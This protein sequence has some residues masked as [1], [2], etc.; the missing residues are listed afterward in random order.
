MPE[1]ELPASGANWVKIW[2]VQ[3]VTVAVALAV[4]LV[5]RAYFK[6]PYNA[7]Q[8]FYQSTFAAEADFPQPF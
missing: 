7:V 2:T 4:I 3:A 8:K 1:N 5:L 6:K